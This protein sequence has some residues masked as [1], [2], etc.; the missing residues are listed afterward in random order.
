M[1]QDYFTYEII[2]NALLTLFSSSKEN[3]ATKIGKY[4]VGFVSV[5]AIEPGVVWIETWRDE[6]AWRVRLS[7]DH[8]WVIEEAPK[9]ARSGTI[10]SLE[11]HMASEALDSHVE[12]EF[13]SLQRWCRHPLWPRCH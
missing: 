7:T 2:E 6:G 9:R 13:A 8:Q 10:V 12:K 11:H 4:G 3:D 5:L 1:S